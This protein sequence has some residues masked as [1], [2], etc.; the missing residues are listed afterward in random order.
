MEP[1]LQSETTTSGGISRPEAVQAAQRDGGTALSI[2]DD[3]FIPGVVG[4]PGGPLPTEHDQHAFTDAQESQAYARLR[5]KVA[6]SACLFILGTIAVA[7]LAVIVLIQPPEDN[8]GAYGLRKTNVGKFGSGAGNTSQAE[9][10]VCTRS[11]A[12]LVWING[13]YRSPFCCIWMVETCIEFA[14][15]PVTFLLIYVI[16]YVHACILRWLNILQDT[17]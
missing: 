7:L 17:W 16:T 6:K 3:T 14:Q 1:L 15:L 12:F 2:F 5:K 13:E 11:Q 8:S 10:R 4:S 9:I